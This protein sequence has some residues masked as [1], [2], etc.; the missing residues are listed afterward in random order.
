MPQRP[1][2]HHVIRP[3][4]S[5]NNGAREQWRKLDPSK[6]Q[7]PSFPYTADNGSPRENNSKSYLLIGDGNATAPHIAAAEMIVF[8]TT[9]RRCHHQ[10]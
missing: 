3:Y 8:T 1:V 6:S 4:A 10:G 9:P 2:A 7:G 5:K